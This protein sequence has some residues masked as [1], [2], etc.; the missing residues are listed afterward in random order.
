M[1]YLLYAL[2]AAAGVVYVFVNKFSGTRRIKEF[3]M[4]L[5]GL[6]REQLFLILSGIL[7]FILT[8]LLAERNHTLLERSLTFFVFVLS[9]LIA[10]LA[11]KLPFSKRL[12]R[13]VPAAGLSVLLFLTLS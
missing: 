13:F 3:L 5:G 12:I 11:I 8:V 9:G 1:V 10:S 4:N 6:T 7:L 2:V